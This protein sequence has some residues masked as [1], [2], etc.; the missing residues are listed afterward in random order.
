L[1]SD[2]GKE[3]VSVYDGETFVEDVRDKGAEGGRHDLDIRDGVGLAGDQA[4]NGET[5]PHFLADLKEGLH[6][7][8]DTTQ[9]AYQI[10]AICV[11]EPFLGG[12]K[13]VI[14]VGHGREGKGMND[15]V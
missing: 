7:Q 5:G 11:G 10:A 8:E 1:V 4:L 3:Q 14:Q 15:E 2:G 13:S 9:T 6:A 12:F